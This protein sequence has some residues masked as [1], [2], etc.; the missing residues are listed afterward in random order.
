MYSV[1][2]GH[3]GFVRW[4]RINPELRALGFVVWVSI[5]IFCFT[6]I[7][8]TQNLCYFLLNLLDLLPLI[9]YLSKQVS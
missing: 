7:Q 5:Y 9:H 2:Y 6:A 3:F 8:N 1:R 4:V